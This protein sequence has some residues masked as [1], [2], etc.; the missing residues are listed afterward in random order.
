VSGLE[1]ETWRGQSR[2][3]Q[4]ETFALVC[5]LAVLTGFSLL[6]AWREPFSVDEYLVRQTAVSGS[7]AAVWHILRT[8]PLAVDPPLYHFLN[9]YCLLLF[10]PSEF[11]TRL[12]SVLAYTVMSFFLY[13][14]V[15]KYTDVCTGLVLVALCLQCGTF[16]FAYDARPYTLVLAADAMALV[17]WASLVE[18]R[19]Q[20]SL[21]LAGLFL[22]IAIAVGSHW[23]GFLVLVPLAL[24][25]AIRT[26]QKRRI[27]A[28]VWIAIAAGAATALAYLPLLTAASQ[29]QALPWKGVAL[30]D[31]SES[32]RLVLEPCVFPLAMLL[33]TLAM[34]RF[35][36]GARP[37][38][39]KGPPIPAP[40]FVCLAAFALIPFPG[41]VIG[42]VLTHAL[43]PRYLLL[44]TIGLLMLVSLAIRDFGRRSAVWMAVALL[45]LG[46]YASFSRYHEVSGMPA[47]GDTSTFADAS[48]LSAHPELPVVPGDND[49]FFRLEAHGPETVRERC[50]F[51]T[52]PSFVRLLHQNTNFL[53]TRALR[54]WTKLPIPD[55]SSFLTAHPQFYVIQRRNGPG[56]LIQRMLEDDAEIALQGTYAGN[57]VYL[58]QVRR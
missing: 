5:A 48:A 52:D 32:F 35:V 25:E 17:C 39:L 44:C 22:G 20:Q 36:F 3:G 28:A 54:R 29:Y 41:F 34:A 49:L 37:P 15:R 6:F 7:P 10:G 12:V 27:D 4:Y 13:R 53:M 26:W 16:S 38:R 58:V 18:E 24:G 57:P 30:G 23:F 46:G 47:G 56:W 19:K 1:A 14:L 43:Q 51:P 33:I 11:S 8:A 40:V 45:I 21:A 2:I 50:V 9:V 42:K 55:L 31:I